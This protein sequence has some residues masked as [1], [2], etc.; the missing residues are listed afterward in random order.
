[1]MEMEGTPMPCCDGKKDQVVN[2]L[3]KTAF[4]GS[5]KTAHVI[6]TLIES[7]GPTLYMQ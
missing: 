1:M 2:Y 5:V 3:K 7:T 4:Y 6:L